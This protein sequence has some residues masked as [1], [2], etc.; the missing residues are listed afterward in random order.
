MKLNLNIWWKLVIL[1]VILLVLSGVVG[2]FL[3]EKD[4]TFYAGTFAF[5]TIVCVVVWY[6]FE[7][8]GLGGPNLTA[9]GLVFL[10]TMVFA[11]GYE[12]NFPPPG[13]V[14][15]SCDDFWAVVGPS[16]KTGCTREDMMAAFNGYRPIAGRS[17]NAELAKALDSDLDELWRAERDGK[18]ISTFPRFRQALGEYV[19]A[20]VNEANDRLTMP[21]GKLQETEQEV[22]LLLYGAA[23]IIGLL[24]FIK[25]KVFGGVQAVMGALAV[26]LG[27]GAGLVQA[28]PP[29]QTL[30]TLNNL[31]IAECV[32]GFLPI[33]IPY[34]VKVGPMMAKKV[35]TDNRWVTILV[36]IGIVAGFV[37]LGQYLDPRLLDIFL[38]PRINQMIFDDTN[39]TMTAVVW[40]RSLGLIT[41]IGVSSVLSG[42][43][44]YFTG[45]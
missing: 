35:Q 36:P 25:S 28:M 11:A 43:I 15:K 24:G 40:A 3:H 37:A 27:I 26:V 31:W 30:V 1:A 33:L 5:G 18:V 6:Y 34:V 23:L 39:L 17:F 21:P 2:Y 8:K 7:K 29:T 9:V 10:I 44:K 12:Y 14:Y 19:A 16:R 20:Y 32:K 13:Y 45:K 4:I 22:F 38:A 42:G 41:G